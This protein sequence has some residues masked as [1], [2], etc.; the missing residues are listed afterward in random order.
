ML[1]DSP[2]PT[3]WAGLDLINVERGFPSASIKAGLS[4]INTVRR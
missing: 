1:P 3:I 2:T 4:I